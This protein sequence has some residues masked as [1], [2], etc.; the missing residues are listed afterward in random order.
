MPPLLLG[1]GDELSN[2]VNPLLLPSNHVYED[3][4]IGAD[5]N[6]FDEVI[7]IGAEPK[8][9]AVQDKRWEPV[10][11]RLHPG[12]IKVLPYRKKNWRSV[13][14]LEAIWDSLVVN[15]KIKHTLA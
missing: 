11:E 13:S 8:T 14:N 4:V 15:N 3:F 9:G 12:I 2:K 7:M 5:G 6:L 1:I 10:N